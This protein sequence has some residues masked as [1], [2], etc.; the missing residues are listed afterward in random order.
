MSK[1]NPEIPPDIDPGAWL[2]LARNATAG[3]VDEVLCRPAA[4]ESDLA[5]LLSPAA[6]NRLERIAELALDLTRARFGRTV[7]LYVPLY[8]S[9]LCPGGC[10]YCG[11]AA[12]RKVERHALTLDEA[13]LEMEAL[14][15][16]G[17]EEI[18]LLTGERCPR[19]GMDYLQEAVRLAA[20]LFHLVAIEVFT[21]SREEYGQLAAAGC[22]GVTIYQETYDPDVYTKMH[23]WG[24]KADYSGRLAAPER[25][26]AGGLRTVGLGAL[27]GLGDP[28]YDLL[29]LYRHARRLQRLFWR[30]GITLSFP[31]LRPES[32][33]F[34]PAFA[35]G[36]RFLARAIWAFRL[37]LPEVPLV[38][39]TRESATFRDGIAG[40]GINKMS[41]G[42]RTTVGGYGQAARDGDR[43]QFQVNDDRGLDLFT[44]MLR[45]KG[46]DPVFKNWDAAYRG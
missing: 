28:L 18:L 38:L 39:S 10:A 25:A 22:T 12:N 9:S 3:Q 1:R 43:G 31:R 8:L 42:S 45:A 24:A 14:A 13:K 17:F 32:G 35:V 41:V 40:I 46:L 33:G 16:A 27:L 2:E 34:Q 5:A 26:L 23:Q 37:L 11:Y 7:Q 30:S 15:S 19:A 20:G 29:S 4:G 44:A 6:G 21:M 36:D